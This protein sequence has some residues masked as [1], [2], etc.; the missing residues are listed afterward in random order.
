MDEAL[1]RR[2]EAEVRAIADEAG[3]EA[4]AILKAQ[5]RV[6]LAADALAQQRGSR[7]TGAAMLRAAMG[8]IARDG[9]H[10]PESAVAD[11]LDDLADSIEQELGS[12]IVRG[13]TLGIIPSSGR[14][15][16]GGPVVALSLRIAFREAA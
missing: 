7:T 9:A 12:S 8:A 6:M 1:A 5:Q 16:E 2:I 13:G 11:A 4:T 15:R 10:L 3:A 14:E